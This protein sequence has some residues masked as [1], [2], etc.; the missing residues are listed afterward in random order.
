[1]CLYCLFVLFVFFFFSSRRRHTRCLSDWSSDVCSSDL[2]QVP[3]VVGHLVHQ[4]VAEDA[5][6]GHHEVDGFE[7][8]GRGAEERFNGG[9]IGHVA[10]DRQGAAS[11]TAD[12]LG[13][14]FRRLAILVGDDDGG[15]L[16]GEAAG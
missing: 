13:D 8:G 14:G 12:L 5:G 4:V 2:D 15:T 11:S 6:A 9:A 10:G 3:I 16:G 7:L 1:F